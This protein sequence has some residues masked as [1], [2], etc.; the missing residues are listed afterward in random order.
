M[1]QSQTAR[2]ILIFW[3]GGAVTVTESLFVQRFW[4]APTSNASF[5]T[6]FQPL[7]A[8]RIG[9]EVIIII[10]WP[11]AELRRS[12]RIR[13]W[14]FM[15]FIK[16]YRSQSHHINVNETVIKQIHKHSNAV[17]IGTIVD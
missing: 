10:Q 17:F 9:M 7:V 4:S 13:G 15:S 2:Q 6:I 12:F 16:P 8:M 14:A 3:F 5:P 1:T 11:V